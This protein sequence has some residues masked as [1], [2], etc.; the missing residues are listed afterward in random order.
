MIDKKTL[1]LTLIFSLYSVNTIASWLGDT[2]I[3]PS[4]GQ[5]DMSNWLLEKQGFM[6]VPIIITEPAIGYGGGLALVYFHDKLGAKKGEPPSISALAAA[7]TENG[8]WFIGGGHMGIWAN[9]KIRYTGGLGTGLIKMEY[10]GLSGVEG[11]SKN[12]AIN[13]ETEAVFLL[14]EIQFRLFD[15][16]FFAGASYVFVDTQNTFK[17]STND[18]STNNSSSSNSSPNR[19]G[20]L[21]PSA[22]FDSRSAALSLQLNYDS[23]D[24]LFT[25]N[26][27]I[28]AELKAMDFNTR[29]GSDQ[30]YSRYNATF[31]NYTPIYDK[32]VLGLRAAAK[33]VE[34]NAPF[35]A[36]PF[37]DMRGV[38]SMQFQGDKTLLGEAELRWTFM[39]RWTLVGFGGAGK[40]FNDGNK[41]NSDL[42]YTKGAGIRYLIASK[43]GLQMG[44]D[45]AKG[46]DNT[47]FYIQFGSSWVM[48]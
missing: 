39:P 35:Y 10:Y 23:R 25:P 17:L 27:G 47:A 42:I 41:S 43:L 32:F 30:N 14:Q 45:I 6:P 37:I 31:L 5:L 48:K 26:N 12:Y 28:A 22:N 9:D 34:G 19:Q 7:T 11:R 33:A 21:L 3:D 24:N 40:A 8:T 18:L 1:I 29:W 4:D 20:S 2:F 46:P 13:F 15:S 44:L 36:Y 16:N 38:K